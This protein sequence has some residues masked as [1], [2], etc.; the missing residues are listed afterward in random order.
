MQVIYR[1][2]FAICILVASLLV[3]E[4]SYAWLF[5]HPPSELLRI[6]LNGITIFTVYGLS[7]YVNQYRARR[8][9][10]S[11]QPDDSRVVSGGE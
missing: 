5:G 4:V 8:L 6:A 10:R 11:N 1:I 2:I 9:L 3:V 7:F